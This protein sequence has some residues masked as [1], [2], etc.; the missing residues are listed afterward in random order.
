MSVASH[1]WCRMAS[2][3][4]SSPTKSDIALALAEIAVVL[5]IAD[6]HHGAQETHATVQL[7]RDRPEAGVYFILVDFVRRDTPDNR[8][9]PRLP[10]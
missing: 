2:G 3:S 10:F 4:S 5:V 6:A 7:A 8:A 1:S 9:A